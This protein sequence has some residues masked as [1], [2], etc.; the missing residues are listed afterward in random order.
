MQS[1][2]NDDPFLKAIRRSKVDQL[3][4]ALCSANVGVAANAVGQ[5]EDEMWAMVTLRNFPGQNSEVLEVN[6]D[7]CHC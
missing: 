7:R 2:V 5:R 1:L 4:I 6:K 3:T